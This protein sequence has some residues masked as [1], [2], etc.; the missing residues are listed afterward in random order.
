MNYKAV[1]KAIVFG[2]KTAFPKKDKSFYRYLL[3]NNVAHYFTVQL[4]KEGGDAEKEIVKAG[5]ILEAKFIKTLTLINRIC[6]ENQLQFI[7]FK[8]YKYIQEVVDGDIDLIVKKRDFYTFLRLFRKE[9]FICE[10][11]EPLKATCEKKGFC[12][13][14]PRVDISFHGLHV[15]N[16][17]DIWQ[18]TQRIK[19]NDLTVLK[20]TREL[21]ILSLLLNILFGPNYC[22][23]YLYKVLQQTDKK[24]LVFLVKN[25]S[26]KRDMSFLLSWLASDIIMEKRFPVFVGTTTFM[27]WWFIRILTNPNFNTIKKFKHLVFFFYMKYGYVLFNYLPFT[28]DWRVKYG[29]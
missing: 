29:S 20:T 9:G 12:K 6:E 21:D 14:E 5:E 22:K 17:K 18:N 19:I 26:L 13:I 8:T 2:S 25:R 1:N 27:K 15:L 10:E 24:K 28:H 4:D 11:S 23:L 16:E 3:L 7:L